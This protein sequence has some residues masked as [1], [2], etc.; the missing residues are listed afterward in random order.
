MFHKFNHHV[1]R[2]TIQNVKSHIG[3]GYHQVKN[4]AHHIDHGFSV[5]KQIYRVLEPAI[6]AIA[7]III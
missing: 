7:E 4:L 6:T 1:F 5:A 2:R 3:H